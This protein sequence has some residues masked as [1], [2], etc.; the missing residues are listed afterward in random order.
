MAPRVGSEVTLR[1]TRESLA[2]QPGFFF[3]YSDTL[4]DIWDDYFL[5]RYYFHCRPGMVAD[6]VDYLSAS[7]N[8]YLV[9]Y[10]MKALT[11]ASQYTRTDAAVLYCARRHFRVVAWI[12]R[13]LPE[14]VRSRLRPPVPLFSRRLGDG[15]G[16]AEDPSTGES[17]GMHRCRLTAEGL[18]D[19]WR[20]GAR[21]LP[22]RMRAVATRFA[23]NGLDLARPHL[24]AGLLDD[25]DIAE[26]PR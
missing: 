23:L 25:F 22:E 19:A 9:P 1:V 6:L 7:L 12:L 3:M 13:H 8:R 11:D 10:H 17:F 4:S 20:Q 15:I 14:S 2:T 18:V 5:V 24:G 21:G 26:G 16:L